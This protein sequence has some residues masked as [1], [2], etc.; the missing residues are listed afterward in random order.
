MPPLAHWPLQT[1]VRD[2]V[3]RLG[4][5]RRGCR[6]GRSRP[7]P[8]VNIHK[9]S[10]EAIPIVLTERFERHGSVCRVPRSYGGVF[11]GRASTLHRIKPTTSSG[12]AVTISSA[13]RPVS[14]T[15]VLYCRPT[16]H[17]T[18]YTS[19]LPSKHGMNR[20]RVHKSLL[21]RQAATAASIKHVH[22]S[23]PVASLS[24]EAVSVCFTSLPTQSV[25]LL[26]LFIPVLNC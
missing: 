9:R 21:P 8:N 12:V 17:P 15:S 10:A 3:R 14:A 18:T 5:G 4:L 22:G 2:L 11:N 23:Q 24:L 25:K 19:S 16:S 13:Q 7:R 6:G 26:C 20:R 1:E